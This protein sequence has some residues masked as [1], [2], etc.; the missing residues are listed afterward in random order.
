MDKKK[1]QIIYKYDKYQ[2]KTSINRTIIQMQT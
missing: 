1:D 2:E